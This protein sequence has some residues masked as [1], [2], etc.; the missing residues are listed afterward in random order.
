MSD[1]PKPERKRDYDVPCHLLDTTE[2]DMA[3]DLGLNLTGIPVGF[4]RLRSAARTDR[5][6]FRGAEYAVPS[7]ERHSKPEWAPSGRHIRTTAGIDR[8]SVGLQNRPGP[9]D[10]YGEHRSDPNSVKCCYRVCRC[11]GMAS[12]RLGMVS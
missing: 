2:F 8:S 9:A 11:W 12:C 6:R 10:I 4:E 5:I 3:A 1:S 7:D